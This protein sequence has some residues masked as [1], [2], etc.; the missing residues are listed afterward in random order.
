MTSRTDY[1]AVLGVSA[2]SDDVVIRAAFKALMLKYHPDTNK[3]ADAT[4]RAAAINEAFSVL[5]D[6]R[7]RAAYDLSRRS[8]NTTPPSSSPSPSDREK[9]SSS[10]K[11]K[12][13]TRTAASSGWKAQFGSLAA[14]VLAVAVVRVGVREANGSAAAPSPVSTAANDIAAVGLETMTDNMTAVDQPSTPTSFSGDALL[15][16]MLEPPTETP[17]PLLSDTAAISIQ[18]PTNI[19]FETIERAATTFAKVL[20]RGGMIEAREWSQT[21]HGEVK[22]NPSW[23]AVDRCAAFDYAARYVDVGVAKAAD[24]RTNSYF[25]FQAANQADNYDV[26]GGQPYLVGQRLRRIE[27]AVEPITYDAVMASIQQRSAK[28]PGQE[29]PVHQLLAEPIQ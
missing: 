18:P 14:I 25:A 23:S 12:V 29:A 22:Q 5:G 17:T 8:G 21:C 9:A 16:N 24:M 6:V 15:S 27:A 4:R 19:D 1:Y 13:N 28:S 11:S 26:V 10:A 2:T 20:S 3:S 7:S